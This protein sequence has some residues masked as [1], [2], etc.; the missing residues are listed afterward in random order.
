[1]EVQMKRFDT[2]WSSVAGLLMSL[3]I[4]TVHAAGLAEV[5]QRIFGMDCAP[6]A[7][8]TERGLQ[9]LDG[10]A[11]VTVSLNEG[12]AVVTFASDSAV[13]LGEIQDI[14]RNNGF[15]P[16]DATIRAIGALSRQNNRLLLVTGPIQYALVSTNS[17]DTWAKLKSL[18]NGT[19]VD[20]RGHV[21]ENSPEPMRIQVTAFDV[22]ASTTPS[23]P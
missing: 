4:G 1:M 16:K 7:H 2:L 14:I 17:D 13:G 15:T 8:A 5:D 23:R 21:P 11:D 18:P 20:I 22:Q 10:V 12:K 6:C 19:R 9:A 3:S